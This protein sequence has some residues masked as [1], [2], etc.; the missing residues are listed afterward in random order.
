MLSKSNMQKDKNS[1]SKAAFIQ[2]VLMHKSDFFDPS[3]Y[4]HFRFDWYPISVYI[5]PI[6]NDSQRSLYYANGRPLVLNGLAFKMTY[7]IHVKCPLLFLPAW[8]TA[9]KI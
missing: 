2:Q 3:V 7:V 8:T 4:I 6:Q 5:I 1:R 9:E